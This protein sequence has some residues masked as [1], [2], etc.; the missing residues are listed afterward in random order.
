MGARHK[1]LKVLHIVE[2]LDNQATETWLRHAHRYL[3]ESGSGDR[4][5][6]FSINGPGAH[7]D[8]VRGWGGEVVH[9]PVRMTQTAA[10]LASL[11]Q[12]FVTREFDAIDCHHDIMSALYLWALRRAKV[13]KRI[14]HVHNTS[15]ALPTPSRIKKALAREPMRLYCLSA[16]DH[17]VGVSEPA[18]SAFL[19]GRRARSGRDH[20]IHCGIQ[21]ERFRPDSAQ[22]ALMR[23]KYGV[24]ERTMVILFAGRMIEYKNPL[25]VLDVLESVIDGGHRAVALMAGDGPVATQLLQEAEGRG[26]RGAVHVLGWQDDIAPLMHASDVMLLPSMEDPPEGLGLGVVEAQAAGL[27]VVMSFSVPPEAVIVPEIAKRMRLGEGAGAWASALNELLSGPLPSRESAASAVAAS[28]FSM[29]RSMESL[30]SLY[31][32]SRT[33]P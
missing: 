16:A 32:P 28:S 15:L 14:V 25:F 21:T 31:E 26:L 1:S 9:S 27:P 13:K 7:D 2:S 22:R 3:R 29:S 6:F 30:I 19:N 23:A 5:T 33:A 24:D 17:I 12:A 10:M 20:V 8:E 11:E 4:W 18:L